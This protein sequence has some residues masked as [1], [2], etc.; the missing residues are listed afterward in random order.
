[1]IGF[2]AERLMELEISALTGAARGEKSTSLLA[3]RLPARSGI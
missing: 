2:A 3:Q 1:M